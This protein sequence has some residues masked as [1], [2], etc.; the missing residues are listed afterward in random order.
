MILSAAD[1]MCIKILSPPL[2]IP[3]THRRLD[4]VRIPIHR[5]KHDKNQGI[6]GTILAL[7]MTS[8]KRIAEVA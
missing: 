3:V 1:L 6:P 5:P 2:C 7:D 4:I 8:I